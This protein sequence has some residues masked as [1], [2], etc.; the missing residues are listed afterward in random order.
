[1]ITREQVN[2]LLTLAA[3]LHTTGDT[4]GLELLKEVESAAYADARSN[5]QF[6]RMVIW[7]ADCQAAT[8]EGYASRKSASRGERTRHARICKILKEMISSGQ[9]TADDHHR[10]PEEIKKRVLERLDQ[11]EFSCIK[12]NV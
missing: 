5:E 12:A 7:A 6:E 1:M 11:A 10:P 4:K 9:Y 8:A 3:H 2:A